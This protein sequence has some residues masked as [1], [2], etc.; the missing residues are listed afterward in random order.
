MMAD[1]A[2]MSWTEGKLVRVCCSV[3]GGCGLLWKSHVVR[4]SGA[5]KEV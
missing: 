5:L 2:L 4:F 3:A 1:L